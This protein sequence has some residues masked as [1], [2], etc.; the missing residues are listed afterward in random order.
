MELKF[1]DLKLKAVQFDLPKEWN[2]QWVKKYVSALRGEVGR[3]IVYMDV[4]ERF[5]RLEIVALEQ[6]V[7][8][9]KEAAQQL[10]PA[11][12]RAIAEDKAQNAGQFQRKL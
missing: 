11:V 9:L 6:Y 1:K 10:I 12:E 5:T 4:G 3:G 8:R 7:P 2:L